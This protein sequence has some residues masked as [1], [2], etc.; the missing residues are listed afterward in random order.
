MRLYQGGRPWMNRQYGGGFIKRTMRK[1]FNKAKSF[2]LKK[3]IDIVKDPAKLLNVFLQG[4]KIVEKFST[5]PS[6]AAKSL[7]KTAATETVKG[8]G[9]IILK[10]HKPGDVFDTR[11]S[12]TIDK[13]SASPNVNRKRKITSGNSGNAKKKKESIIASVKDIFSK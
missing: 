2:L 11:L 6:G 3:M 9:D 10:K 8:V 12:Q 13:F 4:G 5:D 7:L 1:V